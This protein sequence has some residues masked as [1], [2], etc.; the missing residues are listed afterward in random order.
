MFEVR[1]LEFSYPGKEVLKDVSLVVSPGEIVA[2]VG[3][4]GAGKT[5]LMRCLATVAMPSR[6]R[7][8]HDGVDACIHS[9]RYRRQLGYLPETPALYEDMSVKR[10]LIYRAELKGEPSRRIRRRIT[11]AADVCRLSDAILRRKINLLSAGERKRVALADAVLLR[12]RLLLLDDY[13]GGLDH[14]LRE[15]AGSILSE[16]AS[17]SSVIVTG[18]EID[19]FARWCTRFLILRDGKIAASVDT[20][21]AQPEQIVA[22]VAALLKGVKA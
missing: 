22:R 7:V 21:G 17:F 16:V 19:D 3:A 20:A 5:A 11:E 8:L 1:N 15:S 9:R 2:V 4:N 18:H 6:G 13:L 10:F 12:P 14:E